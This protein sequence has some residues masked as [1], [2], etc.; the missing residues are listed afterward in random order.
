M[1]LVSVETRDD[2]VLLTLHRPKA[3]A[4]DAALVA[5][6]SAAFAAH[7]L[8]RAIVLASAMPGLFSAGWDT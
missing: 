4:F 6:L 2:L 7:A 1:S 3:N 8:A 5:E